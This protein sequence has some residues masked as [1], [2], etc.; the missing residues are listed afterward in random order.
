M[1]CADKSIEVFVCCYVVTLLYWRWKV[2]PDFYSS[3]F[4]IRASSRALQQACGVISRML[5]LPRAGCYAL[6]GV[7][8]EG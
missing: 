6:H 8:F 4:T 7:G 1:L 3:L 5:R 2:E